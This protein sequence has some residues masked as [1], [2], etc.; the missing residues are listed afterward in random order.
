MLFVFGEKSQHAI[1]M[2]DMRFP[3]DIIWLDGNTVV[4]MA[5]NVPTEPGK[6]E[7]EFKLYMARLPSTFVLE[8]R[9]GFV[10]KYGL[11]VGDSI[12]IKK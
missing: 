2:R 6:S 8:A 4:D 5:P 11:R 12:F 10:D 1:V 3:I 7:A 9:A